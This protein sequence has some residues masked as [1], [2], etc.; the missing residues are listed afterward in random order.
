MTT[1][2][3]VMT[4]RAAAIEDARKLAAEGPRVAAVLQSTRRPKEYGAV[5]GFMDGDGKGLRQVL[6][7]TPDGRVWANVEPPQYTTTRRKIRYANPV[8]DVLWGEK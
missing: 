4:S 6:L 2:R 8:A 1:R 5:P 3:V 7:V